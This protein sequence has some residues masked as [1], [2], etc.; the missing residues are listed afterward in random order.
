MYT[1]KGSG[2]QRKRQEIKV[3]RENLL[4]LIEDLSEAKPDIGGGWYY[5]GPVCFGGYNQPTGSVLLV[6]EIIPGTLQVSAV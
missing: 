4:F 5:L 1:D 3:N 2:A 6:K